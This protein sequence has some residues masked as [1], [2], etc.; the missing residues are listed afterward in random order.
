MV[1]RDT[2]KE[3]VL[4]V[5]ARHGLLVAESDDEPRVLTLLEHMADSLG[6]HFFQWTRSTGLIR[7]G[8]DGGVYGSERPGNA[9]EHIASSDVPA[10]YH[11]QG[12][13]AG[14]DAGSLQA[15]QFRDAAKQLS[16]LTGAIV[17]TG[18]EIDLPREIAPLATRLVFP[19]PSREGYRELMGR[20]IRDFQLRRHVE[21]DLSA[22]EINY[23]LNHLAGL[24]LLEAEKILTKCIIE[25]G[26]LGTKDLARLMEAKQAIVEREGLLEYYPLEDTLV[27]IADMARLKDW[28]RK[29]KTILADPVKAKEFGLTFPKGMLLLGIPGSGKSLAAKAVAAEWQLPLLKL[30]PS[31]LYNKFI[32]ESEKNFKRAMSTAERMAP[33][34]L[35]I[36][37]IEK[38]FAQGGSED[39]GVSQRI[40]GSFLGW[41]QDR[42]GD[43]FVVATANDISKLPAE[44]LRK[45]RFDEIFFV[46]LPDSDTRREIFRIHLTIREREAEAFDLDALAVATE[47]FSGAEIEQVVV[48]GLYAAFSDGETLDTDLLLREAGMTRPLSLT[49]GERVAWLRDWAR[50]RAVPAN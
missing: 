18:T 6:V 16:T 25:D 24:T 19:G 49:M 47:G 48:S 42:R 37:E 17:V 50:E 36:D 43:V 46:D 12:L 28:L 38:A 2:L 5:R 39:G 23:V 40:L 34:V 32:G 21:V 31:N 10:I 9:L 11:F 22:E 1:L 30:D 7:V 35:W 20:I 41:M 4:L 3:A 44:M 33:V 15:S 27:D 13:P 29:R 14:T 8:M 26:H 45:G